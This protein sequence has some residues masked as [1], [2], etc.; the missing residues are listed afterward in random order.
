VIGIAVEN[1]CRFHSSLAYPDVVTAGV[2]TA[3]LGTSSVRYRIG[4][5]RNDETTAAADG[6][7]VHVFVDRASS[8]RPPSRLGSARFWSATAS[9]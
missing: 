4:I 8:A 2:G 9:H 5:F 1:G 3:H 7:F 6:H